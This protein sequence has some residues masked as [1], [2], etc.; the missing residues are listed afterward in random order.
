M[1]WILLGLYLLAGVAPTVL[2]LEHVEGRIK[3]GDR[4][5]AIV[6]GV[7]WPAFMGCA[8]VLI[9]IDRIRKLL[10]TSRRTT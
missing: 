1:P 6:A 10:P 4:V 8:V 5:T 7:A 9:T 2:V 3:L